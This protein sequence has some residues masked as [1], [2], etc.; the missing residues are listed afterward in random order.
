MSIKIEAIIS[1]PNTLNDKSGWLWRDMAIKILY[2]NNLISI[3]DA[4]IDCTHSKLWK[5]KKVLEMREKSTKTT[6]IGWHREY[7]YNLAPC[8]ATKLAY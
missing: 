5:S 2:N 7:N 1:P 6:H 8:A 4:Q 3:L